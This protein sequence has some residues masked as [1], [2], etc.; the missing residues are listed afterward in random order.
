[1]TSQ[2]RSLDHFTVPDPAAS[3]PRPG[4]AAPRVLVVEDQALLALAL[5]ADL[6][7]MGC[8]I[9]GRAAS[10]E[11]ATDL[12]RREAPDIVLMD[13]RLAG[14]ID[15]IE[16]AARIQRASS[17]RIVFIT[18]FSEGADRARMDALGPAGVIGKPY[19][20]DALAKVMGACTVWLQA[21]RRG[22]A[23]AG[24]AD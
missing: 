24:S 18:A 6:A 3:D 20:P 7:A 1:M 15:G 4:P 2:V 8:M 14:A 9:V 16:A 22:P 19:D 13:V 23:T 21:Q 5:V 17:A 10:G 12:A 11:Q